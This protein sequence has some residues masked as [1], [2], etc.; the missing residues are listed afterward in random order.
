MSE[1][2]TN[3]RSTNQS[4]RQIHKKRV[5]KALSIVSKT[6]IIIA[7]LWSVLLGYYGAWNFVWIEVMVL[8]VAVMTLLLK[9]MGYIRSAVYLLLLGLFILGLVLSL[10]FDIPNDFVPRSVHNY[11]LPFAFLA[12]WLLIGENKLIRMSAFI[13]FIAA[14]VFFSS[15]LIGFPVENLSAADGGRVIGAWINNI[16]AVVMVCVVIYAFF[17]DFSL[18]TQIEKELSLALLRDQL[19]LYYQAQVDSVGKVLGAEVL[20]RWNHPTRGLLFPIDFIPMA[21]KKGLIVLLGRQVLFKACEQLSVWTSQPS[22]ADLTLSV[23][24]SVQE[25]EEKDFVDNVISII[26]RTGIDASKLKLELTENVLI[27]DTDEV[28]KKMTALKEYGVNFSLDDFGTGY[29]S[30]NYLKCLPLN[31]LKIDRNFVSHMTRNSKDAKIVKSTILLGQDLGLDVIAEGIETEQQLKFL[32]NNKCHLFQGYLFCR[33]IPIMEF[34]AYLNAQSS[35]Q[36]DTL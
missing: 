21:E 19:E 8:V 23:N 34:E 17:S 26:K 13:I 33:P 1:K 20:V 25:F 24:V 18:K 16:L 31:Q 27:L 14:F 36:I 35:S 32:Q 12:Y 29:S 30:L 5:N 15:T 11:F 7:V 22:T 9:S 6:L 10:F 2:L 3:L 4:P 28:V